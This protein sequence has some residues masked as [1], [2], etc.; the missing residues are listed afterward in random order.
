MTFEENYARLPYTQRMQVHEANIRGT[1]LSISCDYERIL[2]DIAA[3][4]QHQQVFPLGFEGLTNNQINDA[5]DIHKLKFISFKT[6]GVKFELCK[7]L[8]KTYNQTLFDE[9]SEYFKTIKDL[10]ADRNLMAHGY[11]DYDIPQEANKILIY[12]ENTERSN[13]T[14]KKTIDVD[15]FL[16]NLMKYRH[17]IMEFAALALQLRKDIFGLR[18]TA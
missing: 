7:K 14:V 15:A 12:F 5:L 3:L 17:G 6:M 8:L 2:D 1:Y 18:P 13:S 11:S 4:C 10:I 9:F 16:K